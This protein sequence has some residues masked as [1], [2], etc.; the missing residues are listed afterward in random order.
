[1]HRHENPY[2]VMI[3]DLDHFKWIND[4]LGHKTGDDLLNIVSKRLKN[5]I[6]EC[7]TIARLGGD[8]FA[9]L[10]EDLSPSQQIQQASL[11]A[12]RIL[13]LFSEPIQLEEEHIYNSASIGIVLGAK[14][15]SKADEVVR[16]ADIAMYRAKEMGKS[17]YQFFDTG[18]HKQ[19][20]ETLF[21]GIRY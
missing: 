9:I 7:D 3:I 11:I 6:R 8:E 12:I 17:C 13:G 21:F 10:L 4:S 20:I 19:A 5:A 18:M 1:M 15:Y 2:A 16:D 14:R